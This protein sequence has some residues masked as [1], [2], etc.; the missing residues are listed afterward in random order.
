MTD[1]EE[2]AARY[3]YL[4]IE[5]EKKN[6]TVSKHMYLEY[7]CPRNI[8]L[9]KWY[10]KNKKFVKWCQENSD[11]IILS[12]NNK[13]YLDNSSLIDTNLPRKIHFPYTS[14]HDKLNTYKKILLARILKNYEITQHSFFLISR[15]LFSPSSSNFL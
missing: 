15:L 10:N 4:Y 7:W 14:W 3:E 13:K 1:E 5:D 9:I 6:R 8:K 11:N 12:L 2:E